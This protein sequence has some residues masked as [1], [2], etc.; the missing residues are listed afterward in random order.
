MSFHGRNWSLVSAEEF[1][2]GRDCSDCLLSTLPTLSFVS[3]FVLSDMSSW[4]A[5]FAGVYAPLEKLRK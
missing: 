4:E 3:C 5:V 2:V 1:Q